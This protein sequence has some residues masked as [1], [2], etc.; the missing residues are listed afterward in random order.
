MKAKLAGAALAL[1]KVSA[2]GVALVLCLGLAA[3]AHADPI[4]YMEALPGASGTLDGI[5]FFNALLTI[6]A[7]G[8]TA[9]APSGAPA[10]AYSLPAVV[11]VAGVGSDTLLFSYVRVNQFAGSEA[12]GF[13]DTSPA[14]NIV[15]TSN[16]AFG[17]YDLNTAI[18]PTS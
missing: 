7:T 10:Q 15:I 1:I 17:T 4:T 13:S 3:P 2:S 5:P 18:G 9:V 12:A 8:D 16:P 14:A 11:T 6:T